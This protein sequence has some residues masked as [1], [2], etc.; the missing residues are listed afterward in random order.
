MQEKGIQYIEEEIKVIRI[1]KNFRNCVEINDYINRYA[2]YAR[3][4]I[5]MHN[6]E[7][8]FDPDMFLRGQ[9]FRHGEG[10]T[11]KQFNG[12]ASVEAKKVV[13]YMLHMT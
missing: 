9:A 2:Q 11:I 1:E 3:A 10:V 7:E 12:N 5:K 8:Q 4:L 13:E 6:P